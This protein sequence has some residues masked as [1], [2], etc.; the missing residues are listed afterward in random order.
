[1]ED[2]KRE[3]AVAKRIGGTGRTRPDLSVQSQAGAEL[4]RHVLL[5]AGSYGG[6]AT[7]RGRTLWAGTKA[8]W[9]RWMQ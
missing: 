4:D 6:T 5:I 2:Q 3:R 9:I 8:S 1:M 7:S